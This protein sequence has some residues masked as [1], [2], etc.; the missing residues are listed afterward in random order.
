MTDP[1][2]I[3]YL[4][5]KKQENQLD[6]TD[7]KELEAWISQGD[8]R[9]FNE[10]EMTPELLYGWLQERM[11]MDDLNMDR[12]FYAMM[13]KKNPAPVRR[14]FFHRRWIAAAAVVVIFATGATI[15]YKSSGPS[16]TKIE[17]PLANTVVIRPGT[18]KAHLQLANG[19]IIELDTAKNGSIASQGASNIVKNGSTIN[20][21]SSNGSAL[22]DAFNIL[23][24]PRAGQFSMTLPDGTK[25]WL[26]NASNLKYPVNFLGIQRRV[27]LT[28]EAYFEVA[29][30]AG[31]PFIVSI[32]NA[33]IEVLGTSF[34]ISCY[35][36]DQF[37]RT[38]LV[39]GKVRI[40]ASHENMVLAPGEQ[41]EVSGGKLEVS[42]PDI[43][44]VTA[45]RKGFFNFSDADVQTVMRQIARWYDVEI[46]YTGEP[47]KEKLE[48]SISR[49]QNLQ[50]TLAALDALHIH[51][52]I[53]NRTV[54][55]F[56]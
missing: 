18:D 7:E 28:G 20:Y 24:T 3:A 32:P 54:T 6:P 1:Q 51:T 36:D 15:F 45:W 38:T 9:A 46:K 47:S 31:R 50:E 40:N 4:I 29:K 41:A 17:R 27:E 48:G 49:N 26:N 14:L 12:R 5:L 22:A 35:Q 2:R 13:N 55:V 25:V 10:K 16:K 23:A 37:Q 53:D 39:E 30:V 44:G 8:N 11:A 42:H 21:T 19:T 43:Y 33:N 56:P 34:N 52:K